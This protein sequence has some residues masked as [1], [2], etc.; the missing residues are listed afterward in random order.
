MLKRKTDE[1]YAVILV[2][3]KGKR[4]KPLST[5]KKPKAFLSVTRDDKTMFAKTL[6]RISKIIPYK[7]VIVV[8]N[9]LHAGLVAKDFHHISDNNLLLEPV[10]KNTAPAIAYAA[11][12]VRDRAKDAVMVIFPTDQ[13][14]IDEDSY[15]DSIRS[16]MNFA[17]DND[18]ILVVGVKPR[19]P[20]TQFGY[21][22]VQMPGPRSHGIFKVERFTEKPDAK[23]AKGYFNDGK[24]LWNTGVFIFRSSVILDAFKKYAPE[25]SDAMNDTDN[26]DNRYKKLKDIS[27]DYSVL[28]KAKNIY[29]VKGEFSWQDMGSFQSLADILKRESRDF[30]YKGGKV[31]KIL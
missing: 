12:A 30:V 2:G 16:G 17:I 8:A 6:D 15:F 24:Y 31:V 26:I 14:I 20:S 7:N 9:K 1:V 10:S 11:A 28:E 19:F 21:V 27:I 23:T 5:S 13:Y 4:L 18:A 22:R 25:I 3:G 29:C